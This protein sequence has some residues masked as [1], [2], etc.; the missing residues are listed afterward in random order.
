MNGLNGSQSTH[1]N[2]ESS[3]VVQLLAQN[4]P[5]TNSACATELKENKEKKDSHSVCKKDIM[6]GMPFVSKIILTICK[7]LH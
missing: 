3:E 1:W 2:I 6:Y 7:P 4:K 5:L